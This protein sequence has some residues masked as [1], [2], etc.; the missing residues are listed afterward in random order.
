MLTDLGFQ[1][2]KQSRNEVAITQTVQTGA[3]TTGTCL[4]TKMELK[5]GSDGEPGLS[6]ILQSFAL[7]DPANQSSALD[8]FFFNNNPSQTYTDNVAFPATTDLINCIGVLHVPTTAYIVGKA[9]TNSVASVA[10]IGMMLKPDATAQNR[11]IWCVPVIRGT[12]TYAGGL[13]YFKFQFSQGL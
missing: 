7:V 12:P 13:L 11:S 9:S 5:D 1:K 8:L 10:N 4:G 2:R 6:S 3:Y